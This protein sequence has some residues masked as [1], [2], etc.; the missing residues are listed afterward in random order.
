MS[1]ITE[2]T[3]V[4]TVIREA[5]MVDASTNTSKFYRTYAVT[6]LQHDNGEAFDVVAFHWGRIGTKGQWQVREV[7]PGHALS[8][9]RSKL[10]TKRSNGY[11]A[12][13][14]G[15]G[16][17]SIVPEEIIAKMPHAGTRSYSTS[18]DLG[19]MLSS[20]QSMTVDLIEGRATAADVV[21]LR[22]RAK[23]AKTLQTELEGRLEALQMLVIAGV[24]K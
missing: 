13:P 11:S 15:D 22:E 7:G 18:L 24:G 16:E 4:R 2:T 10:D 23:Q 9:A 6:G 8:E 19:T 17:L 1:T 12:H 20:A 3:S 14:N 21:N 5:R